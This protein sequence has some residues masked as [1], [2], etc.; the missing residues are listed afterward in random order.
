MQTFDEL[1]YRH[2]PLGNVKGI[3]IDEMKVFNKGKTSRKFITIVRD[4][5]PGDVLSVVQYS[6][7]APSCLF[8]SRISSFSCQRTI[9]LLSPCKA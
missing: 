9:H 6:M 4:A 8:A 3:T 1:K 2:V 7:S 5:E